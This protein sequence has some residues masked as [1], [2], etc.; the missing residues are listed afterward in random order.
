[1]GEE[2]L[3]SLRLSAVGEPFI[4]RKAAGPHFQ[5][6]KMWSNTRITQRLGIR[7]PLFQ[8]PMAGVTNPTLV[9]EVSNAGGL[10]NLGAA[11]L[12]PQ[13]IRTR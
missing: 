10:G 3:S 6:S 11:M 4:K 12:S 9:A 5:T 1:M 8:A 7:Y 2:L 13:E